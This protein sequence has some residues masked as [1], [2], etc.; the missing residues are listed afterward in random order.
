MAYPDSYFAER[1]TWRDWRIEAAQLISLARLRAGARVLE[2]GCGAGGL[3]E[4]L[5]RAEVNPVGVDTLGTALDSARRRDPAA[6]LVRVGGEAALPFSRGSFDAV[7]GQHVLEHL[8]DLD[9][10]LEE[11]HRVL[12]AGGRLVVA[13]PNASYPDPAHFADADHAHVYTAA[14]LQRAVQHAGFTVEHT[15]TIFP[16]LSQRRVLRAAG[17]LAYA[18]FEHL[19]YW[20]TRGRTILL[21]ASKS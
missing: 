8:H 14:E 5:P 9:T 17:V 20:N 4:R 15:T 6:G 7:I 1:E 21:A 18:A 10:A 3:L 11:W 13:T 16:Y 2:V 19:P 12:V